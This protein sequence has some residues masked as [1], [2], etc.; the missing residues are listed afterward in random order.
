ML[1]P[2]VVLVVLMINGYKCEQRCGKLTES[3][4]SNILGPAYNY[5]YMSIESPVTYDDTPSVGGKRRA[6]S[7]YEFELDRIITQ[8]DQ[9]AWEIHDHV[10]F[11][12]SLHQRQR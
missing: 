6:D 5:R 12:N 9:P 11:T 2:V 7:Y 1:I 10:Q 3:D 4:L 8:D